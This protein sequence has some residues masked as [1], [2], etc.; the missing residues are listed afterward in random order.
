MKPE[1]KPKLKPEWTEVTERFKKEF[2]SKYV[3]IPEVRDYGNAYYLHIDNNLFHVKTGMPLKKRKK[4]RIC[5]EDQ[6]RGAGTMGIFPDENGIDEFREGPPY[7]YE[8]YGMLISDNV[9][10][11]IQ[12]YIAKVKEIFKN[13]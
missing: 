13:V 6:K 7:A 1:A 5:V 4:F 9:D 8:K 11:S 2:P 12:R 10:D 3:I